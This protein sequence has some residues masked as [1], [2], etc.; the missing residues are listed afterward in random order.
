MTAP[1]P[2]ALIL[3]TG[4][5]DIKLWVPGKDGNAPDAIDPP[6]SR[7]R[8]LHQALKAGTYRVSVAPPIDRLQTKTLAELFPSIWPPLQPRDDDKCRKDDGRRSTFIDDG[9]LMLRPAKIERLIERLRKSDDCRI[10]RVLIF[11]S[12]R[13]PPSQGRDDDYDAEP[14]RAAEIIA[15]WLSETGLVAPEQIRTVNLLAGLRRFED[16][17]EAD[18][19]PLHRQVA[20]CVD[21][22]IRA[23]AEGFNGRVIVSALGGLG[24]VKPVVQASAELHFGR[25]AFD[26]WETQT[27]FQPPLDIDNL[28][29]F[30]AE[31]IRDDVV[32]AAERLAARA[33][34]MRRLKQG[35]IAGAWG[36]IAH[37]AEIDKQSEWLLRIKELADF[38]AGNEPSPAIIEAIAGT[39]TKLDPGRIALLQ[40]AFQVE[41]ALQ[42]ERVAELRVP[43]ALIGTT[44]LRDLGLEVGIGGLL[45]AI[46]IG[47]DLDKRR[48]D[49]DNNA[50]ADQRLAE[51]LCRHGCP[52]PSSRDLVDS[53]RRLRTTGNSASDWR[54]ILRGI[55]KQPN[56]NKLGKALDELHE[57]IE[58]QQLSKL[59]NDLAHRA[60]SGADAELACAKARR[61]GTRGLGPL[62]QRPQREEEAAAVPLGGMFLTSPLLTPIFDALGLPSPARRYENLMDMVTKALCTPVDIGDAREPAAD[63]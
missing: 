19:Y 20:R 58:T 23:L 27:R 22:A 61:A 25:R 42:G 9:R 44:A 62:W 59:R 16:P 14:I 30:R 7:C 5:R 57:Y 40:R 55:E 6:F 21:D 53:K 39:D 29:P 15:N 2:I 34:A 50:P 49:Q 33:S 37:L 28:E 3:S 48:I 10:E 26:Y 1:T 35:D 56:L 41:A 32:I 18:D 12:N 43:D 52:T 11:Y 60:L 13:E 54:R 36:A 51:A 8:A 63:R 31:H 4:R 46:G 38:F 45:E 17:D 24:Q 47:F